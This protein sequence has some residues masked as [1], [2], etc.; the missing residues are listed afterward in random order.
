MPCVWPIFPTGWTSGLLLWKGNLNIFPA[1]QRFINWSEVLL[2]GEHNSTRY[3]LKVSG[4]LAVYGLVIMYKALDFD[5]LTLGEEFVSNKKRFNKFSLLRPQVSS[6]TAMTQ[7]CFAPGHAWLAP[8]LEHHQASVTSRVTGL[9]LKDV[10][11]CV[12]WWVDG[13]NCAG[14]TQFFDG[15]W[16]MVSCNMSQQPTQWMFLQSTGSLYRSSA[17]AQLNCFKE[18]NKHHSQK[19]HQIPGEAISNCMGK[20]TFEISIVCFSWYFFMWL[21]R[22]PISWS[23]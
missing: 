4:M 15:K 9:H 10:S 1:V 20:I 13:E 3:I 6:K 18:T 5:H 14:N 21:H 19:H 7:I 22:T 16:S 8:W 23:G 11:T 12:G 17:L 2:S